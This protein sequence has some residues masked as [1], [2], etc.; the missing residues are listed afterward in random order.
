MDHLTEAHIIDL[1]EGE[2]PSETEAHLADC[3][4][5]RSTKRLWVERIEALREISRETIDESELHNLKVLYRQLGPGQDRTPRWIAS[6]VRSSAAAPAAARGVA[7]GEIMEYHAGPFNVM[8]RVGA[9]GSRPTVSVVGQIAADEDGNEIGGT[10]ALSSPGKQG[11]F[12]HVDQFG[13]FHM[14]D[15]VPG[16]YRGTWWFEDQIVIVPA[17]EIGS[18]DAP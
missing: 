16:S 15:V 6:L 10:F 4:R 3:S 11:H 17:I 7:S 9:R 8:L 18:D 2:G 5:C 14:P 12:S 1:I 13:E